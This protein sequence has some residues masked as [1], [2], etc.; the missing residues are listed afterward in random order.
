MGRD[1][2]RARFLLVGLL[3]IALVL[4]TLDVS[5]GKSGGGVRKV[6]DSIV[7]PVERAAAAAVRPVRDAFGADSDKDRKRADALAAENA[8]LKRQLA[9]DVD[10]RRVAAGLSRLNLQARAGSYRVVPARVIAT[11]DTTGTERTVDLGVGSSS[12]LK[13]GQLVVDTEG[14]VGSLVR[15]SANVAT[16]RLVDDPRT[17]IGARL[18]TS[19]ALGTI[20][21]ADATTELAFTLYDPSLAVNPG[22][23]VV[24]YGSADYTAGI[25]IGVTVGAGDIGTAA[26]AGSLTQAVKVRPYVSFGK[27]DLVGVIVSHG[28]AK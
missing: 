22:L 9:T 14:L 5:A 2:R 20:S 8:A 15:V 13:V 11:G 19:R 18:V 16:V 17:I 1:S 21:G 23:K 7:G 10:A 25:P 3:A 4:I 6:A 24:T 28:P 27:L 12:G 26:N